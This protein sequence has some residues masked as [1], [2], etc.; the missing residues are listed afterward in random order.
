MKPYLIDERFAMAQP[1]SIA[2]LEI[3]LA[4]VPGHSTDS[5]IFYL[6][7]H[8]VVFSGDTLFANSIGRTDLPHGS[9]TQLLRGIANHLMTLPPT[10][11]VLPGHGPETLIG[12]E[13]T[14]NPH[15]F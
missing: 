9:Q 6:K 3:S 13:A 7:H 2:G 8:D 12:N 11:R 15:L 4:H 10:T 14:K 1:L 5:V